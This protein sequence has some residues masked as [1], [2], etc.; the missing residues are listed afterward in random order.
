[1]ADYKLS[2][3]A[4]EIDNRLQNAVLFSEQT[5]TEEQK[6]QIKRNIGLVEDDNPSSTGFE[7]YYD[8]DNPDYTSQVWATIYDGYTNQPIF[9]KA[10]EIPEKGL[11][12]VGSE[13]SVKIPEWPALNY[14]F[15][16]T[17]DILE[18]QHV[19]QGMTVNATSRNFTQIFHHQAGTNM[20]STLTVLAICQVAGEYIIALD[21]WTAGATFPEP[22]VYFLDNR[23]IWGGKYVDA[24]VWH[25]PIEEDKEEENI[26]ANN[27][28]EIEMFSRGLFV[29][30]S[31]TMGTFD[32][33]DGGIVDRR[34]SY[35]TIFKRI[36]NIDVVNAGIAGMTSKGWY[37]AS[38]DSDSKNGKWVNNEWNWGLSP[39]VGENDVVSSTLNY[40]GYDFSVIHLGIN[41]ILIP[42]EGLDFDGII[43][44]F[45]LSMNN[46]INKIKAENKGIKIFLC[47][48]IP[49]YAYPG[50]EQF[51]TLNEKIREIA[52]TTD[53]VFLI[54]LNKYSKCAYGTPYENKH[55]TALGYRQMAT[56]II[57]LINYTIRN[58]LESFKAVQ[59]IG[60]DYS[61]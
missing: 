18:E 45:T 47:T 59:F 40:S 36:T 20:Y 11:D 29:G 49:S 56:E 16:I 34:Y 19:I 46:I 24:L 6:L 52:E 31:I 5:L 3:T 50:H 57:S 60:T 32:T 41:D 17:N 35:P 48:I 1:M 26:F 53:D 23:S 7:Y 43:S 51:A 28:Y 30:D 4:Q 27:G 42:E 61:L 8:G 21:G 58:N 15:T 9:V 14:T 54:D 13:V 39:Y 44:T 25:E 12:L 2:L 10:G 38:F 33:S 55:L 37:D 22:G